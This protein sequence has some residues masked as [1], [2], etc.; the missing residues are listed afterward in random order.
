M[1]SGV[2]WA[3]RGG[4]GRDMEAI[5]SDA[6]RFDGL[7]FLHAP[8][9]AG[10]V[11]GFRHPEWAI[12]VSRAARANYGLEEAT[13]AEFISGPLGCQTRGR[14]PELLRARSFELATLLFVLRYLAQ[15]LLQPGQIC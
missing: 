3:A 13:S 8:V 1:A 9:C 15:K 14:S 12:R 4:T 5:W 6:N 11:F 2:R 7:A 10:F